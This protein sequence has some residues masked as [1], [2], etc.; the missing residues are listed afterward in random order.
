LIAD[1]EELL[2]ISVDV[3]TKNALHWYIREDILDE[4]RP[5]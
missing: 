2:G 5:L 3:V 4:A 1:L